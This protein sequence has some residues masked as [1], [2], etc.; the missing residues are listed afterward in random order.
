MN[1]E[2]HKSL[3][4]SIEVETAVSYLNIG[5]EVTLIGGRF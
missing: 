3:K 4:N 5:S 2:G 1:H